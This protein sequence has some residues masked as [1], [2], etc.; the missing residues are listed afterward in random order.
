M[1]AHMR[2]LLQTVE[3]E[4]EICQELVDLLQKE[5]QLLISN[6]LAPLMQ[7]SQSKSQ[8]VGQFVLASQTR[9]KQLAQAGLSP[10][11]SSMNDL[12]MHQPE[13]HRAW[14]QFLQLVMTAKELNRTNGLLLQRLASRNQNAL[15]AIQGRQSSQLY[16]PDGQKGTQ[17]NFRSTIG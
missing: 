11:D 8:L 5:E 13:A 10:E 14:N 4:A 15:M 12:L 1:T 7:L 17:L 16:G 9:Y 3:R 6:E 2:S